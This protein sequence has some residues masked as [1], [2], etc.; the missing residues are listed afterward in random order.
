M[1]AKYKQIC[2][3]CRKNYVEITSR[4]KYAICYDC[5]KPEMDKEIKNKKMKKL[6]DIPEEFYKENSFL[7]NIKVAY[8]RY[9]K[10][11]EK[12]VEAFKNTVEKLNKDKNIK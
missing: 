9:E 12:Q 3:S 7:R 1:S 8:N 10:L 11:S 5:Q 6:F 4:Q 2:Y